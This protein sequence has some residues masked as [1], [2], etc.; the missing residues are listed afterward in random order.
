[1]AAVV[2]NSDAV[3]THRELL[4]RPAG[5]ARQFERRRRYEPACSGVVLYLG[6]DRRY[7]HLLHH[8]FVFSRDPHEE[9]EAIYRRGEPAP[10]PTCYVC[11][12]AAT[13]PD[14]APARRRGPVRPRPRALPPAGS[15]L[16]RALSPL[17]SDDPGQARPHRRPGRPGDCASVVERHLTPR[18]IHDRYR[19]LDGAIYGLASHGRLTGAFKPANRS[20]DV[21]G[22]Y[23]AGGAAHPGTGNADGPHVGMDRG[24]YP[25]SGRDRRART[26]PP[27]GRRIQPRRSMRVPTTN[28]AR[29]PGRSP[30]LFRLFRWYVRRY[31]GPA[32]PC[33]PRLPHRSDAGPAPRPGR[34]GAQS[35]LV[36]GP[37]D[38]R[39]S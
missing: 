34:R 17:P 5:T 37:D 31:V 24:R 1:M 11:A 19:V 4:A 7:D 13:D 38:R 27:P 32:F 35:P 20:P 21:P 9:F 36:V 14:V 3:R 18:D 6:L 33:R 16:G 23:L 28:D 12:P 10:D 8:N 30:R 2:S 39:A 15:R 25:R 26:G 22:L 29:L